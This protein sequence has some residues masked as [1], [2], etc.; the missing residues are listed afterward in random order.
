M[1]ARRRRAG[2]PQSER[3]DGG[4]RRGTVTAIAQVEFD[5]RV[6]SLLAR[7][8]LPEQVAGE[9]KVGRDR[10]AKSVARATDRVAGFFAGASPEQ[11]WVLYYREHLELIKGLRDCF[12]RFTSDPKS[13]QYNAA[14]A[15][16][17]AQS[18]LWDKVYARGK[19]LGVLRQQKAGPPISAPRGD[20][21]GELRK[22]R[23]ILDTLICELEITTERQV[24]RAR[25]ARQP[26]AV[27]A[28]PGA[29][30]LMLAQALAAEEDQEQ[31]TPQEGEGSGTE[32]VGHPE[33]GDEP[34]SESAAHRAP[35]A[36]EGPGKAGAAGQ[37][38]GD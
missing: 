21:L 26:G 17:R 10:V 22:E 31:G 36:E 28:Q 34:G 14:I 13:T 2:K 24:I 3:N 6:L 1:T 5:A 33:P 35:G 9:L 25:P 15:A 16:V 32:Q 11:L 23:L 38:A 19:E 30:D 37:P 4:Y 7:G 27:P 18:D 8:L 29:T 12:E 20:V